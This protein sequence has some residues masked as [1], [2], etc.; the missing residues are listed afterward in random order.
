MKNALIFLILSAMVGLNACGDDRE[1]DET[2]SSKPQPTATPPSSALSPS[3]FP[4]K[5]PEKAANASGYKVLETFDVGETVFVRSLA[6]DES[7]N[8]IWIGTTVGALQVDIAS[9]NMLNTYTRDTGF[10]NEYIFGI[11][12]DSHGGKW[13]GTNGGGVSYLKDGNWKTY[14]P[15]HGLADY[16]VYAFAEQANGTIWIG[17]WYGL[18]TYDVKTEEFNTYLT[19]LVNEWVYGLAVDSKDQVWIGTEGGVNMFDGSNWLTWTHE[20]GLGA[21]NKGGLSVSENTGLGTRSRHD[22]SVMLEGRTTYNPNYIFTLE[23]AADDT[24]WAGTWGGGASHFD[25][26]KWTNYTQEQGLAGDIVF[27]LAIDKKDG[28]IWFGTNNGLSRYDGK[29]WY[30]F[31]MKDG[32]LDN[33][34]YTIALS[35]DGGVWVGGRAGVVLLGK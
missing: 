12:A 31:T 30:T 3:L 34:I 6:I 10:A 16:W 35:S 5:V 21:A 26:K 2:S 29:N 17:T 23:V 1:Q 18:N 33:N 25:G 11:M 20:D 22:L 19:E 24:V 4:E 15:M 32:L 7:K 28:S 14:F 13:F 8:E 9:R 27:A